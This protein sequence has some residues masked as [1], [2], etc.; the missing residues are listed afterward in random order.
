MRIKTVSMTIKN[1]NGQEFDITESYYSK[2][3]M[4]TSVFHTFAPNPEKCGLK[5]L[6][7]RCQKKKFLNKYELQK[8]REFKKR[9]NEKFG[10]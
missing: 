4:D 3:T 7:K 9:F 5:E 1:R 10:F 2:G 8:K 6:S